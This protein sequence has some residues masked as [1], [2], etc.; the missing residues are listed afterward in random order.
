MGWKYSVRA[1]RGCGKAVVLYNGIYGWMSCF[2]SKC[3]LES[4]PDD[5]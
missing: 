4:R 5:L 3:E 2:R 1:Y